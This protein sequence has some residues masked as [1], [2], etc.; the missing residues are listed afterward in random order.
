MANLSPASDCQASTFIAFALLVS[1]TF[2]FDFEISLSPLLVV[3]F[4]GTMFLG[5]SHFR[6]AKQFLHFGQYSFG[7]YSTQSHNATC[8]TFS[9]IPASTAYVNTTKLLQSKSTP[10]CSPGSLKYK[11]SRTIFQ[12]ATP[13]K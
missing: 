12:S 1:G 9:T 2:V 8:L 7:S 13:F 6:C 3:V 4:S 10:L 11:I 5:G